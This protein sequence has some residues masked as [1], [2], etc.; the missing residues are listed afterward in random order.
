VA[1]KGWSHGESPR[2]TGVA[3]QQSTLWGKVPVMGTKELGPPGKK[4]RKNHW[5]PDAARGAA[6]YH[7][8]HYEL[9]STSGSNHMG[10]LGL[11]VS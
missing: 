6:C 11:K 1:E 5:V 2:A 9:G 3:P 8:R 10:N 7:R 4:W